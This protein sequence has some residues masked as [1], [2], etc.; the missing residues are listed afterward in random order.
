[1]YIITSIQWAFK[2]L[3]L[4]IPRSLTL[5]SVFVPHLVPWLLRPE[6]NLAGLAER[7]ILKE[8]LEVESS[9]AAQILRALCKVG[10]SRVDETKTRQLSISSVLQRTKQHSRDRGCCWFFS[11]LAGQGFFLSLWLEHCCFRRSIR[12]LQVTSRRKKYYSSF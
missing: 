2:W 1:M 4:K 7:M 9:K 3:N 10:S 6:N 12:T 8:P 11:L 5:Q